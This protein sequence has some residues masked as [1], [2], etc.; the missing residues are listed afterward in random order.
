MR[1]F[2]NM[3][4]SVAMLGATIA[5]Y[6]LVTIF[7]VAAVPEYVVEDNRQYA[8]FDFDREEVEWL[9]IKG[10]DVDLSFHR[11]A[12]RVWVV[13]GREDFRLDQTRLNTVCAQVSGYRVD[14]LIEEGPE[15]LSLYGLDKPTAVTFRL[16]N[17]NEQTIYIGDLNPSRDAYYTMLSIRGEYV[18]F[19]VTKARGDVLALKYTDL[20]AKDIGSRLDPDDIWKVTLLKN[21]TV[22]YEIEQIE[23]ISWRMNEPIKVVADIYGLAMMIEIIPQIYLYEYVAKAPEDLAP[24]GLD[25]PRYELRVHTDDGDPFVLTLGYERV[26]GQEI[27][28][29][30]AG[31]G[32]DVFVMFSDY[33]RFIDK[34]MKDMVEGYICLANI[35]NVS[36]IVMEMDGATDVSTIL[37]DPDDRQFEEFTFNGRKV[38][39]DDGYGL[40]VFR[41]YFYELITIR[42][43]DTDFGPKPAGVPEIRLTLEYTDAYVLDTDV[44]EFIH[45]NDRFYYC[46]KNGEDAMVLIEKA[47]FD[48]V[49][50]ARQFLLG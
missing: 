14:A 30:L 42:M 16:V 13:E 50:Y 5:A 17:G 25:R 38:V 3:V 22:E 43:R 41:N 12:D 8:I 32:G 24:Y 9:A 36:R 45:Y 21:G 20:K 23:T 2:K 19:M 47:L 11:G 31:D 48:N 49:R 44:F 34:P 35:T 6:V 4:A 40:N 15:D 37:L 39:K 28:G 7:Y 26:Q 18:V 29:M 1:I 27:Y 33:V 46:L 10:D